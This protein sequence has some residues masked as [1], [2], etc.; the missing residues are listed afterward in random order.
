MVLKELRDKHGVMWKF[1]TLGKVLDDI[2]KEA[3]KDKEEEANR[4][5]EHRSRQTFFCV[6]CSPNWCTPTPMVLKE[7]R[8]KHGVMWLR[9]PCLV[10]N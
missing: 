9:T 8:D 6:G 2:E 7:L 1:P 5:K 3:G 4:K 10:T